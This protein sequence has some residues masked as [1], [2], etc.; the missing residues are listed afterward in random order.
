MRESNLDLTN[1]SI[2]RN[3]IMLSL[4]IV[5]SN[6]LQTLYNITDTYWLGKLDLFAKEA[7]AVTGIAF[8]LIFFLSSFGFGFVI[9]GTSLVAQYKG[10][11]D[12]E[13]IKKVLSQFILITV[14][15]SI[16]FLFAGYYFLDEILVMLNTPPEILDMTK[17][18]LSVIF[19]GIGFMFMF[20]IFQSIAHG[21]GDTVSPMKAQLISVV[22]NLII[23]PLLIFGVGGFP[24]LGILGAGITTLGARIIAFIVMIYYSYKYM[25]EYLPNLSFIK[26][27][28]EL[29]Y[30]IL[31]ISVPGSLSQSMTSFGFLLLQ[32]FVNYYGT[33]VISV[34]SI[35]SRM[36][37]FYMMP[38]MGIA[39]ALSSII[40][41]N[42]GANKIERAEES[43]KKALILVVLIMFIGGSFKFIFGAEITKF[44][45]DDSEIIIMGIR[46]FKVT[47]LASFIFGFMFVFT[48]VFNGAGYTK[49]SMYF[50]IARLWIF[51]IPMVLLFSGY[52]LHYDINFPSFIEKIL[53]T[54][55]KPL[56]DIPYD[57]LWWSMV[58]SNTI[59]AVWA[60]LLYKKGDWKMGK[61]ERKIQ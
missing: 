1:G 11:K 32:G 36:T 7:V 49:E 45:I 48:G 5:F 61:I 12:T 52:L 50:N 33:A 9:A 2:M 38:A 6:F 16:I 55:S 28:K 42:L 41:Q 8:P 59:S 23:D 53:V 24:K 30:K 3:L 14:F 51:R 27:D 40:G 34:Y 13:M 4:P 25:R 15:F 58:V 43:V 54:L 37:G 21:L 18:Y 47:A 39:N 35:G 31:S 10:A 29:I 20:M 56:K 17:D 57:A 19:P 22:I 44:F 46:M 60:Y 26:P